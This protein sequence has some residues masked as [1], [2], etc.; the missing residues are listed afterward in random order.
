MKN[1]TRCDSIEGH[2]AAAILNKESLLRRGDCL[3]YVSCELCK[4]VTVSECM[5][6]LII[7]DEPLKVFLKDSISETI[8][9]AVDDSIEARF[10][11]VGLPTAIK[12]SNKI[13]TNFGD[14]VTMQAHLRN[15]V[16]SDNRGVGV[17]PVLVT[18]D[19]SIHELFDLTHVVKSEVICLT[20]LI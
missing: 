13:L 9:E 11:S 12:D 6:H 14:Q 16:F 3:P 15:A 4:L 2:E 18:F 8:A 1:A 10:G 17:A 20:L 7:H 19:G 5:N